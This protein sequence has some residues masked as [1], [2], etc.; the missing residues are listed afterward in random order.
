MFAVMRFEKLK[1]YGNIGGVEGHCARTRPTPNADP[2]KSKLNRWLIGSEHI[3]DA[4]KARIGERKVRKNAV[5]AVEFLLTA[6]PDYFRP[7]QTEFGGTYQE[8]R[9]KAFEDASLTWLKAEFG[10]DNVVSAV[11]HLDE[12]TPHVHAILVPIDPD[13]NKLNASRWFDGKKSLA[14]LQ[15]RFAL[16]VNHL[17]LR[18]GKEHSTATHAR[19]SEYYGNVNTAIPPALPDLSVEPPPRLLVSEA[20]RSNWAQTESSRLTFIQGPILQ[21]LTDAAAEQKREKRKRDE[22]EHEAARLRRALDL[23]RI[24]DIP[25]PELFTL[26]GY[27]VDPTNNN[28]YLGPLGKISIETKNGKAKFYNHDVQKGGGGAIDLI[29]HLEGFDFNGACAFLTNSFDRDAIIKAA[30]YKATHDALE[31]L[32]TP[33]PLPMPD[34]STWLHVRHYLMTI[35]KL[36]AVTLDKLHETGKVFSDFRHNACFA[37]GTDGVEL[38]SITDRTWRGFRGKKTDFFTVQRGNAS[39]AVA[40]VD[41]ALEALSYAE[42]NQKTSVIAGSGSKKM[43]GLAKQVIAKKL[44][45]IVAFG[46]HEAGEV[47]A[48]KLLSAVPGGERHRPPDDQDWNSVLMAQKSPPT[49]AN[50]QAENESDT[51]VIFSPK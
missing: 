46:A 9:V 23:Q 19:V 38:Q 15:T 3:S 49:L 32:K 6:S 13:T 35:Y 2:T 41:S 14:E 31:A 51:E 22:A 16:S 44:K 18:R 7:H 42:M 26:C 11:T 48:H 43:I 25:L 27:T 37:Y 40:F 10:T 17:G 28:Q 36:T 24:R 50:Q 20:S 47:T 21:P 5:L 12:Q 29:M 45:L 34:E 4:V 39:Q 30:I 1:T 8:E 33:V